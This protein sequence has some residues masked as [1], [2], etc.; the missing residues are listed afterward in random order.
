MMIT[1]LDKRERDKGIKCCDCGAEAHK[2]TDNREFLMIHFH[3]VDVCLCEW[4]AE[5]M[6]ADLHIVGVF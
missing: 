4:C 2:V 3:S 6:I 5:S 1:S